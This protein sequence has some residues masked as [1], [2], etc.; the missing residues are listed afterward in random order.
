[1]THVRRAGGRRLHAQ[2]ARGAA[3]LHAM[4]AEM[5]A[6]ERLLWDRNRVQLN[7]KTFPQMAN[8]L[9]EEQAAQLCFEFEAELAR[10]DAA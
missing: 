10:L 6:A 2:A 5:R 8:W 3:R 7:A 9:P 4:L 1:M